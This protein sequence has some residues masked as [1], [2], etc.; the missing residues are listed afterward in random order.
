MPEQRGFEHLQQ[1]Q[2]QNF[3]LQQQSPIHNAKPTNTHQHSRLHSPEAKQLAQQVSAEIE[4]ELEYEKLRNDF[5]SRRKTEKRTSSVLPHKI[6]AMMYIP[7]ISPPSDRTQLNNDHDAQIVRTSEVKRASSVPRTGYS[8]VSSSDTPSRTNMTNSD[9]SNQA[10]SR[11]NSEYHDPIDSSRQHGEPVEVP[12]S[13]SE[14]KPVSDRKQSFI[15]RLESER[16]RRAD[17]SA[18]S[19]VAARASSAPK[20]RIAARKEKLTN[21]QQVREKWIS[22]FSLFLIYIYIHARYNVKN[23]LLTRMN[24]VLKLTYATTVYFRRRML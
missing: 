17:E 13:K 3:Q 7:A 19:K 21:Y 22:F 6:P 5:I 10:T 4:T 14:S 24:G 20:S 11:I 2:Q 23:E 18:H 12:T 15:D 1:R 9:L 16:K 8:R